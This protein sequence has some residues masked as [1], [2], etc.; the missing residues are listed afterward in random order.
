MIRKYYKVQLSLLLFFSLGPLC[1]AQKLAVATNFLDYANCG[2][3]NLE[4]QVSVSQ[5]FSIEADAKYNPFSFYEDRIMRKQRLASIGC[6]FWPWYVYSGWW[7]GAKAQAQ[8][9]NEKQFR[10]SRTAEGERYGASLSAG[11]SH[12]LSRH[13]NLEIG[14]GLWAGYDFYTSYDCPRCGTITGK[15]RKTFI[16]PN[17]LVLGLAFV[18]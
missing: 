18:F 2:T 8:E 3:I 15:G 12:M 17:D 14:A 5:K 1:F 10:S 6:R 11:Y 13:L 4:A 16:L 9:Y 7:F